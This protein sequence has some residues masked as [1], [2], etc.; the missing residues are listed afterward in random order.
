M[1]HCKQQLKLELQRCTRRTEET[2]LTKPVQRMLL[3]KTSVNRTRVKQDNV[4]LPTQEEIPNHDWAEDAVLWAAD[5]ITVLPTKVPETTVEKQEVSA[6]VSF[7]NTSKQK[8]EQLA[9]VAQH[10]EEHSFPVNTK[11]E[12][13]GGKCV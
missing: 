9:V 8:L 3:G 1:E 12:G 2:T 5:K 6:K 4:T 11:V 13:C 10:L 7:L